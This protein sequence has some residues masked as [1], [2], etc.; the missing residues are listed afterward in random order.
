MA[1]LISQPFLIPF[2]NLLLIVANWNRTTVTIALLWIMVGRSSARCRYIRRYG[3]FHPLQLPTFTK[4]RAEAYIAVRDVYQ[5]LYNKEATLQT[6]Q[7]G[8]P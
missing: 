6:E 2:R 7:K 3:S 1:K 5:E 8:K 4:S